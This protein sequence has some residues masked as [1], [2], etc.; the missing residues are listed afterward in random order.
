MNSSPATECSSPLTPVFSVDVAD[1]NES[2]GLTRLFDRVLVLLL[3]VVRILSHPPPHLHLSQQKLEF[4]D[5][6]LKRLQMDSTRRVFIW[7]SNFLN[8]SA[9]SNSSEG[10]WMSS[11]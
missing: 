3:S 6:A 5:D 11:P 1:Q 4:G 2:G 9:K 8:W 7:W 10:N